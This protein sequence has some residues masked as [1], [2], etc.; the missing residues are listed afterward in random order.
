MCSSDLLLRH[1]ARRLADLT[2]LLSL[3]SRPQRQQPQLQTLR[4][5]H[6]RDRLLVFLVQGSALT[7]SLN[8]RLPLGSEAN[9]AILERWAN[10]S[11]RLGGGRIA[12][13]RLPE[14][15]RSGGAVLRQGLEELER[16]G[17][18]EPE[19]VVAAGQIGRA[20]V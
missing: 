8:L 3:I 14:E 4:L 20:H 18:V 15:L 9:L 10:D 6:S 1:L 11:L 2:G 19:G 12:W 7:S 17:G 5:V 13:E 16:R